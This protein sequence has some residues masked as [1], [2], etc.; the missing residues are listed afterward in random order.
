MQS[1][2]NV[3]FDTSSEKEAGRPHVT[4]DVVLGVLEEHAR[5]HDADLLHPFLRMLAFDAWIGNGDRHS[6]NWALLSRG[7]SRRLAPMYDTA[8][9]LGAELQDATVMKKL[10]QGEAAIAQYVR[11]CRSGFGDGVAVAG[12]LQQ[13]LLAR[14]RHRPEWTAIIGDFAAYVSNNLT[15]VGDVLA[16]IPDG[17]LTAPRK[18]LARALLV[19]RAKMLEENV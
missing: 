13:D 16:D 9:S 10:A 11:G 2:L 5:R 1:V 14:L 7:S 3:P 17:W 4:I 8:G 15:M 6:G 18:E 12:V 19:A